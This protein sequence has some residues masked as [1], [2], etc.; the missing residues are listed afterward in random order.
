LKI[1]SSCSSGSSS[2]ISFDVQLVGSFMSR[3]S[4]YMAE[5]DDVLSILEV[6]SVL[7]KG[8]KME[9]EKSEVK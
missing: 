6:L 5:E 1:F 3:N 7:L 9:G 2:E 8:E 4:L